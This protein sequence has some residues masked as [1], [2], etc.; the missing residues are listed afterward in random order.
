MAFII[1]DNCF[2]G[3]FFS[4]H[5]RILITKYPSFL[6]IL[7]T[8]LS[9]FLFFSILSSQYF[10]FDF[11]ILPDGHNLQPCQKHPSTKMHSLHFGKTKSGFPNI[12]ELRFHPDIRVALN[13][14]ISFSSVLL[15]PLERICDITS[16]RFSF[17][18]E[19]T[20]VVQ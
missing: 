19:S 10:L 14:A 12:L 8:F 6:R 3:F 7:E 11:G 15:F 13:N 20:L 1:L 17:E 9:R 5:S 16:E 2:F 4:W 18:I